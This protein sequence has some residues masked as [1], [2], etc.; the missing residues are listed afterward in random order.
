MVKVMETNLLAAAKHRAVIL[1]SAKVT[2]RAEDIMTKARQQAGSAK[3]G[4]NRQRPPE[5]YQAWF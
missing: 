2:K 4:S 5:G 3:T 1:G